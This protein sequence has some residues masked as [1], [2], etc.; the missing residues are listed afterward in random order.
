MYPPVRVYMMYVFTWC[1][2]LHDVRVY[3][4][5]V[6]ALENVNSSIHLFIHGVSLST[7]VRIDEYFSI[8]LYGED[9]FET[10]VVFLFSFMLLYLLDIIL[11][12]WYNG[13]YPYV[14]LLTCNEFETA[15]K[16]LRIIRWHK[17]T[18]FAYLIHYLFLYS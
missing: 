1:T 15:T 12:E 18:K 16:H 5:Y 8:S 10:I 3:M 14:Y 17:E 9:F 4:M 11:I 6:F 2:C 7:H 13:N